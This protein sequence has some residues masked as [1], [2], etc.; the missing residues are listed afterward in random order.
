[1]RTAWIWAFGVLAVVTGRPIEAAPAPAAQVLQLYTYELKDKTQFEQG[2]RRH[3]AWH[4][5]HSDKLVWY[6]WMVES[7]RRKGLFVDGTAGAS[8]AALDTRP[9]LAGDAADARLN[10]LPFVRAV[11][12]ETWELWPMVSTA[13]PLEDHAP[14]TLMDVFVMHAASGA[15]QRFERFLSRLAAERRGSPSALTWYKA[16]RGGSLP[17]YM[18]VLSRSDWADIQRVGGTL[19][20]L[21]A[22]AYAAEPKDLAKVLEALA[23]VEVESWSYQPRLSLIPD[24]RSRLNLEAGQDSPSSYR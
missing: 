4:V 18:L 21:L 5:G 14:G 15:G 13:T 9:D 23:D 20:E 3:L 6:G 17:A 11:N 7:G 1:M 10:F 12:V 19:S 24:D 22:R 16:V 2:Y 8:Y